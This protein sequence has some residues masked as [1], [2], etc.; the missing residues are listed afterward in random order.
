VG[1]NSVRIR[2]FSRIQLG[3]KNGKV[4]G[5]SGWNENAVTTDNG[6]GLTAYIAANIGAV[7]GSKVPSHL[8]LATQTA[9][10]N[11]SQDT[12]T[13][14]T[15]VRKSLTASTIATGTLQMEPLGFTIRVL[16]GL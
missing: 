5:D 1:K 11:A 13:G 14:E 7:S 8:Q 16:G 3:D 12:L 6:G 2:G 9:A 15:R 10:F 4:V